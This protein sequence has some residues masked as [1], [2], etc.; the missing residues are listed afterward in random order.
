MGFVQK[1]SLAVENLR[2]Q[3]SELLK[4]ET[5]TIYKTALELVAKDIASNNHKETHYCQI[6]NCHNSNSCKE[7]VVNYYINNAKSAIENMGKELG[8]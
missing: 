4:M 5:D 3:R 7:C 1:Q 8:I 6:S 2:R